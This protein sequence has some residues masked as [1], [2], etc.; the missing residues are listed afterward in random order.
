MAAGDYNF[1]RTRLKPDQSINLLCTV[2]GMKHYPNNISSPDI[3]II[4]IRVQND[5][6]VIFITAPVEQ[7][8]FSTV[9]SKKVDN[10]PPR[11]IG[12]HT[13]MESKKQV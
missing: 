3:D 5:D 8:T 13:T 1:Y 12:F 10:S 11:E 9:I 2:G 7:V 6:T 4:E